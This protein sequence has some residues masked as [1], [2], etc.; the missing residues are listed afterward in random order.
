MGF[1]KRWFFCMLLWSLAPL[2]AA[3]QEGKGDVVYV[4]TP[5]ITVDE[6]LRMAK[7]GQLMLRIRS[8]ASSMSRRRQARFAAVSVRT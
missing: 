1:I 4:P 3:A 7:G 2:P 6:M 5:Q 8:S